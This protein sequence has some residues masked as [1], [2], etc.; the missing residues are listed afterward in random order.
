MVFLVFLSGRDLSML[1]C[2]VLP[3]YP[4]NR[5]VHGVF[6]GVGQFF[7][8]HWFPPP[9]VF[10]AFSVHDGRGNAH[11]DV[12]GDA[13]FLLGLKRIILGYRDVLAEKSRC[14]RSCMSN[15]CFLF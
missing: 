13:P 2:D 11:L 8:M 15:E 7:A 12:P 14:F 10:L 9:L 4:V 3:L 1:G 5:R 6:R